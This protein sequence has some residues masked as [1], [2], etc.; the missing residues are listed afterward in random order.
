MMEAVGFD[1]NKHTEEQIALALEAGRFPHAVLIEGGS[2]DERR[3]LALKITASLLCEDDEK[4]PCGQCHSCL[5]TLGGFHPDVLFYE[6]KRNPKTSTK[7]ELYYVDYIREI[8]D[9]SFVIP[10]EADIKI[11]VLCEAQTMNEQAQNAFLK[12]LEEPP[13]FAVFILLSSTKSV[14]L[15]TIL[16][17]VMTYTLSGEASDNNEAIPREAAYAAAESVTEAIAAPSHFEIVRAAGV[18]DKNGDLL[19]AALPIMAEIFVGAL[20]V[21]YSAKE[22]DDADPCSILASKLSRRAL[23]KL[24]DDVN[25]LSEALNMNANLNLTITRLCTLFRSASS[26]QE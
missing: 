11:A 24:V 23:L 7:N 4:I 25:I 13:E 12:I 8:R 20:R 17:R 2:P 3:S 15:P 22:A 19:K 18:F 9:S 10:M 5:K 21:K 1:R 14:F 26:E 6:P 16:S